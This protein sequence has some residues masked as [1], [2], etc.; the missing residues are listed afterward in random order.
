MKLTNVLTQQIDNVRNAK[1]AQRREKAAY[2]SKYFQ[3]KTKCSRKKPR[4]V[5]GHESL[6]A[7]ER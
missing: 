7:V 6:T 1:P 4:A 2:G 3:N 5:Y